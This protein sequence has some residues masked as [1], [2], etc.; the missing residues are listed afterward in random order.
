MLSISNEDFI[1]LTSYIKSKYGIN[2]TAKR[3]LIEGRL[4]NLLISRG[5]D[6]FTD[7][8]KAVFADKTGQEMT[9]L[10][11]RLTTNHTYFMREFKCLE[12]YRDTILPYVQSVSGGYDL[13]VWSAGCSSGEE[14]YMIAMINNDFFLKSVVKWDTTVLA[15]DISMRALEKAREGIYP[16][17]DLEPVPAIWKQRYFT[18]KPDGSYEAQKKLKDGV[19]FRP[20]N[21]ME[22]VFPFKKKFHVVFC[23]NVMIYFDALT[24]LNLINKFYEI[25]ENG[26]YLMIGQSESINREQTGYKYVMPSIYR[27]PL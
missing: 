6:N 24:K 3:T 15:T 14:P 9:T 19:L 25:T 12:F 17:E 16:A 21:L 22:P 2:L 7:Y 11:N 27:K 20:F 13:R 10:L 18:A 8:L 5:F 4:G 26:G 23:R 1:H